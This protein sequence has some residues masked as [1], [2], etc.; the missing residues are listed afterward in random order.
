[1]PYQN[2]LPGNCHFKLWFKKG[3]CDTFIRLLSNLIKD[4]RIYKNNQQT[5]VQQSQMYNDMRAGKFNFKAFVD[6]N[7]PS[8]VYIQQPNQ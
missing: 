5:F 4:I 6:P 7:D 8:K 1:L 3:G 2:L